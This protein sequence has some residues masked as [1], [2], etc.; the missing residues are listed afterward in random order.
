MPDAVYRCAEGSGSAAQAPV[1]AGVI[2]LV[3]SAVAPKVA[4]SIG[5]I[6]IGRVERKVECVD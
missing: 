2:E 1:F 5:K 6:R 4:S 3:A